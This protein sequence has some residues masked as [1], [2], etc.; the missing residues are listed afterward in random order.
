M[1]AHIDTAGL[2]C[3]SRSWKYEYYHEQPAQ[4]IRVAIRNSKHYWWRF[5]SE[6]WGRFKC[7]CCT[8]GYIFCGRHWQLSKLR[9]FYW[10]QGNK[11]DGN[12]RNIIPKCS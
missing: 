9:F 8:R 1:P 11:R 5:I 10:C 7:R 3:H 4:P 2:I 6:R 12:S